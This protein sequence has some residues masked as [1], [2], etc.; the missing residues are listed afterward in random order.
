MTVS[1]IENLHFMPQAMEG[2]CI[3]RSTF[4]PSTRDTISAEGSFGVVD[5]KQRF[6]PRRH[7]QLRD[8]WA[9]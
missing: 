2:A 6:S 9:P 1:I 8:S 5:R 3:E 7:V 4:S